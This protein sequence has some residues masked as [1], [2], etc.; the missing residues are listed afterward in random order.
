MLRPLDRRLKVVDLGTTPLGSLGS[1]SATPRGSTLRGAVGI[2]TGGLPVVPLGGLSVVPSGGRVVVPTDPRGSGVISARRSRRHRASRPQRSSACSR[3]RRRSSSHFAC[4]QTS[5]FCS[6]VWVDYA[7]YLKVA[8][9][10]VRNGGT[11]SLRNLSA[12]ARSLHSPRGGI[13]V[14]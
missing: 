13:S 3:L 10:T 7:P 2:P 8:A 1:T 4:F 5:W 12:I 9:N 6:L 11:L 14:F